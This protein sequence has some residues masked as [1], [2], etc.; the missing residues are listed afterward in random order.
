MSILRDFPLDIID[1]AIIDEQQRKNIE[2][3]K[4]PMEVRLPASHCELDIDK[5]RMKT[6]KEES[7]VIVI[8]L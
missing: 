8:E 2:S 5:A 3:C 6:S 7:T 4:K 1:A